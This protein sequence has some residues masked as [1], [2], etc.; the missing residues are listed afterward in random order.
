M[1][2]LRPTQTRNSSRTLAK[3]AVAV[4]VLIAIAGIV[5][6]TLR[7]RGTPADAPV[8]ADATQAAASA[9]TG[10][11]SAAAAAVAAEAQ[12]GPN[13]VA[14]APGSDEVS[15]PA[16][17]KLLKLAE[18]AVKQKRTVVITAKFE[19]SRPDQ[20]KL[21]A[22]AMARAAAVRS[23]LEQNNVQLTRITTKTVSKALGEAPANELNRVDIELN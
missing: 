22:L 8:A 12:A 23:V 14:F 7:G 13:Q 16:N 4:L 18:S 10:G 1:D 6:A 19:V 15:E 21:Q 17:T 20:A 9:M 3:V 5:L 2:E 11:A